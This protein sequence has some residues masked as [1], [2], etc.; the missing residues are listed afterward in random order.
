MHTRTHMPTHTLGLPVQRSLSPP[1][2]SME[3]VYL[4]SQATGFL[5]T[6]FEL[7]WAGGLDGQWTMVWQHARMHT[8]THTHTHSHTHAR[9]LNEYIPKIIYVVMD[10]IKH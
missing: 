9:T 8:H 10:V 1:Q 4:P 3:G 2:P 7:G 6:S 5:L